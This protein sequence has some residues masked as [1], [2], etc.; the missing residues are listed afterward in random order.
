MHGRIAPLAD[1][2]A[3]MYQA[4]RGHPCL[5]QTVSKRLIAIALLASA[6]LL[7]ASFDARSATETWTPGGLSIGGDG[8]WDTGI[9]ANW[10]FLETWTDGNAAVFSGA[11]GTVTL[12]NPIASALTFSASGPYLLE[13]GTLQLSGSDVMVDSFATIS[14]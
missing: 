11:G 12:V 10:N 7:S 6:L 2:R 4:I 3:H 13:S 14:S 9:T 5:A 1:D 8:T